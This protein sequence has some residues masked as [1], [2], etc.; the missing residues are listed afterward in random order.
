MTPRETFAA[1]LLQAAD[2][3]RQ[4]SYSPYSHFAV[5]AALRG[6]SGRIYTGCNVECAAYPAGCCAERAAFLRAVSEGECSF[7]E[8]A[9]A[10]G[11]AGEPPSSLCPPC[12]ICRQVMR[13][14]CGP[15]FRILLTDGRQTLEYSLEELLPLSF[16][17]EN[18]GGDCHEEL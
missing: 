13:E 15:E 11:P 8:I 3:A 9:I 5:G 12:G 14:F 4:N 6:K 2:A 17:P 7:T 10:G 1:E 16:G 18:L